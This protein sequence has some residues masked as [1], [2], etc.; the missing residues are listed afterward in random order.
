MSPEKVLSPEEVLL[1]VR[2]LVCITR[3]FKGLEKSGLNAVSTNGPN[4]FNIHMGHIITL[5]VPDSIPFISATKG[6][7]KFSGMS[8]TSCSNMI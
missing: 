1:S 8:L 2:F 4:S 5:A 6:M 7:T 3:N